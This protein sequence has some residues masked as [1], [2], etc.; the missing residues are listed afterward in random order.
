MSGTNSQLTPL[1]LRKQ[2]LLAESEVNRL[3]LRHEW[4]D[5]E[6]EAGGIVRQAK[7]VWSTVAST[8]S[9]GMAGY[10]AFRELRSERR[11][12][13]SSWLGTIVSG[14]RLGTALWNSYRS[15]PK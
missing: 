12:G 1:A 11:E 15:K 4:H 13:K 2:L 14:V 8:V 6:R 10:N 9:M 3:Q 5:L 7:S